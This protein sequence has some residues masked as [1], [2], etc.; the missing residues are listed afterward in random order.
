MPPI[1]SHPSLGRKVPLIDVR[2]AGVVQVQVANG[3]LLVA[4][5]ALRRAVPGL[6]GRAADVDVVQDSGIDLSAEA[7]L[8]RLN[9]RFQ[10]VRRDLHA[11]GETGWAWSRCRW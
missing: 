11:V 5:D 6:V 2:R 1:A 9:I 8:H 4:P 10:A 3:P 7:L